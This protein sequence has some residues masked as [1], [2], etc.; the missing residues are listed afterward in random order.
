M[1]INN[2][3]DN[4][5]GWRS[6]TVQIE[7]SIEAPRDFA[8]DFL[9]AFHVTTQRN[10]FSTKVDFERMKWP[11]LFRNYH[12]FTYISNGRLSIKNDS[13]EYNFSLS[14]SYYFTIFAIFAFIILAQ[15]SIEQKFEFSQISISFLISYLIMALS[16]YIVA[17]SFL[18]RVLKKG[19]Q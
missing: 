17:R 15:L 1:S 13:I 9:D 16:S 10:I 8:E 5:F 19:L 6:G 18:Q 7:G 12:P 2:I 4:L 14:S 3:S 11:W